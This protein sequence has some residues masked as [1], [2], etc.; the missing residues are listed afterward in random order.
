MNEKRKFKIIN[1]TGLDS[2]ESEDIV[3]ILNDVM[4]LQ[5]MESGKKGIEFIVRDYKSKIDS[6]ESE[7]GEL[8]KELTELKGSKFLLTEELKRHKAVTESLKEVF[9]NLKKI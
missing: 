2:Y 3:K 1:V 6:F 7:N 9:E 4:N 8:K 5:N